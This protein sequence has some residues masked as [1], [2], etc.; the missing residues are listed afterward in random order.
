MNRAVAVGKFDAL[1]LGHRALAARAATL[2]APRL[3]RL[4]GLAAAFGWVPRAPL[5][6]E[7]DRARVLSAWDGRPDEAEADL[8]SLRDLD[9]GAFLDWLRQVHGAGALVVGADFRCGRGRS[10]GVAELA[11]L[12]AARGLALAVVEPV[13]V[14]GAPASSSRI[15]A[16]LAEGDVAAAA[17]CLGRPHRL[18][19]MVARGDGR[20][21][22]LGFPTANLGD[23][24]S[25]PPA[26]GVYAAWAGLGGATWPAAVNVGVLP[27]VGGERPLTIEAHLL[28]FAGDAYGRS[29][30]LDLVA[31]LRPEQ[32]FASLDALRQ[33]IG[34]DVA[35]VGVLLG[36]ARVVTTA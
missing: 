25:Q 15:R 7:D 8:R 12:C 17:A 24:R 35:R 31:R 27:T 30:A 4:T 3:L 28:G 34:D 1:H 32:R 10:A 23:P 22:T 19:G 29:L 21:R 18:L 20:G 16:A 9:A 2:G 5:L 13:L 36:A 33:Q 11:P 26:T 14:A 6:A